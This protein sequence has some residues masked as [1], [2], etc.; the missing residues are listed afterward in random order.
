[1]STGLFRSFGVAL[2]LAA[3]AAVIPASL[4]AQAAKA[5]D[6]KTAGKASSA[7]KFVP[8]RL[9]WG[10]PDISGNEEVK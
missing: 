8:R 9:P 3:M 10:D 5:P 4:A 6:N 1:M 2:A 7:K